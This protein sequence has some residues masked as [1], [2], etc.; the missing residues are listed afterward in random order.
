LVTGRRT[1]VRSIVTSPAS[2]SFLIAAIEIRPGNMSSSVDTVCLRNRW[3]G[4]VT[5]PLLL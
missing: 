4:D 2:V 5:P 1:R 3:N